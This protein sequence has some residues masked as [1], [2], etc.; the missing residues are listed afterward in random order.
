M[1]ERKLRMTHKFP[2][3]FLHVGKETSP[4]VKIKELKSFL[5]GKYPKWSFA[6][7]CVLL[8]ALYMF[9][10]TSLDRALIGCAAGFKSWQYKRFNNFAVMGLFVTRPPGYVQMDM[11]ERLYHLA[12]E[13]TEGFRTAKSQSLLSYGLLT[14]QGMNFKMND[15]IDAMI[16]I[17]PPYG[18]IG[19]TEL[20][21]TGCTCTSMPVYFACATAGDTFHVTRTI[22]SSD[23]NTETNVLDSVDYLAY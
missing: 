16:S 19:T 17:A 5:S 7:T 4:V 1:Y 15:K 14:V 23:I 20:L 21:S 10:S 2:D 13:I 9:K 3:P 12:N 6:Q 11:K 22:R 8:S 18:D